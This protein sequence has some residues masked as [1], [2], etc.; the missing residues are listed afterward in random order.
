MKVFRLDAVIINDDRT[1]GQD[2]VD[3]QDQVYTT[4]SI[5]GRLAEEF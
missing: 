4:G 3:V 1:I 2:S 5:G